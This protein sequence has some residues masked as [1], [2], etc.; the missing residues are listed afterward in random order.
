MDYTEIGR[1]LMEDAF[2]TK[3]RREV[4]GS[5]WAGHCGESETLASHDSSTILRAFAGFCSCVV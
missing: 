4:D 5:E 1:A 2:G 3:P